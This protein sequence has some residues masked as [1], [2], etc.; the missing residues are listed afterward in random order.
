MVNLSFVR[1]VIAAGLAALFC[2]PA[3]AQNN[4]NLERLD[5]AG[6]G[7]SSTLSIEKVEVVNTNLS[8]DEVRHLFSGRAKPEEALAATAR[9]TAERLT[10]RGA[11][12][13]GDDGKIS[14]GTFTATAIDKGRFKKA[15]LDKIEANIKSGGKS[16]EARVVSRPIEMENGDIGTLIAAAQKGD[17]ESAVV[18]MGRFD[19]RGFEASMVDPDVP[20]NAPGGNVAR[21][22]L[23]SLT[24]VTEYSGTVP[25]RMSGEARGILIELPPASSAGQQ[26]K[27]FGYDRIELGFA[28]QAT[29]DPGRRVLNL[30]EYSFSGVQAGK[31]SMG[32][33]FTGIA[34]ELLAGGDSAARERAGASAGIAELDLR[35]VDAGLAN[36]AF[37]FAAASQGKAPAALQ[38]ETAAMAG[39]LLPLLLGGD[40]SALALAQ[41]LQTFLRDPRSFTLKLKARGAPVP[42]AR[43]SSIAD[44][45]SFLA[46]VEVTLLANQ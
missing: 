45:A 5:I 39:Q 31:L 10:I 26:L 34:P 6:P 4:I 22:S 35:F 30:Q 12:L 41:S 21:V 7:D 2:A 16:G 11:V 23:A 32:G 33:V 20:A 17:L 38:A 44:P 40:P 18:L 25:L 27:A 42:V 8:A 29:Y 46:L 19:W 15:G 14:F 37:A 9:M 3:F 28:A 1:P 43:L 24:G 36:R 13:A